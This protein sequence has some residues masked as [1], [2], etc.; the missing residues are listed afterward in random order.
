MKR[1]I[2]SVL[3][4]VLLACAGGE[5]EVR[6]QVATPGSE[7]QQ[8]AA[9]DAQAPHAAADTPVAPPGAAPSPGQPA[10]PQGRGEPPARTPVP[11]PPETAASPPAE[12]AP[13]AQ[14]DGARVLRGAAA[15]YENIRS[16]QAD[17][18]MTVDNP[19]LRS[20]T[21]SRGALYQ[22]RPDRILLRFTEPAGD[23]IVGDGTYFW[24]YYPSSDPQQVYRAPASQA[25]QGGVDLQAQFVGDPVA[26]FNYTLHGQESVGGRQAHVL[27]MRPKGEADYESLKVWI[28]AR[29]SLVRRF[30]I[31]EHNAAVR[32]FDLENLRTNP[33]LGD[34]LFR[35][36]PPSG[37]RVVERN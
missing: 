33:T 2:T 10:S 23:V 19:L 1:V 27:T 17:F 36:T 16:M 32:R 6:E 7:V 21:T 24:I 25:G 31:T 11:T 3:S 8:P 28:D 18:T 20:R 22:R 14:D 29:D 30:E 12:P 4:M 5:P 15:A 9:P 26:R 34:D 37:A 35:F 13:A